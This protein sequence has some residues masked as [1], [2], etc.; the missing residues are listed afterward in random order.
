MAAKEKL[1]QIREK[2]EEL[3]SEYMASEDFYDS[4]AVRDEIKLEVVNDILSFMDKLER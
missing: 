1:E 4:D 2:L 3:K